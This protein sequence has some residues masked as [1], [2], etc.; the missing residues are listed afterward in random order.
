MNVIDLHRMRFCRPRMG[1][2]AG[3]AAFVGPGVTVGTDAV[4][5]PTRQ[6]F[7]TL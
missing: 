7:E 2:I 3:P 6:G 4:I 5:V 1:R